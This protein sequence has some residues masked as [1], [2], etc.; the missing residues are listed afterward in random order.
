M[1][2]YAL[3]LQLVVVVPLYP[4]KIWEGNIPLLLVSAAGGV[5]NVHILDV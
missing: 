3:T 1:S 2:A 4:P 5:G